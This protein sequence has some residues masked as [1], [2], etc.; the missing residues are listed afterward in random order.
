MNLA[1][2]VRE[3]LRGLARLS[4][5]DLDLGEAALALAALGER[6]DR[7]QRYRDFLDG[8]ARA[9]AERAAGT[10]DLDERIAA[11]TG[12]LVGQLGFAGDDRDYDDLANANLMRVIDRRRGLPVVLGIIWLRT[13]RALGWPMQ[14]LNFP[15]HFL[16]RLEGAAGRRAILDPFHGGHALD[17]AAL[18]DLLKAFTGASAELAAKHYAPLSDRDVLLRLENNIKVQLLRDGRVDKALETI[19]TML[20]FAP[21]EMSLWREAGMMHLHLGNIDAAIPVLEQFVARAPSSNARHRVSA[22]L[23][24]LRGRPQ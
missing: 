1:A 13:G 15:S 4:D 18:R 8:A 24:E 11:L 10:E 23:Q 7:R 22:L 19:E 20:L 14:A 5:D 3:E 17:A 16:V 21:E 9:V 2:A 6:S 12:V